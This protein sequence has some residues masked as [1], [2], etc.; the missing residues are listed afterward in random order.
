MNRYSQTRV[1]LVALSVVAGSI[2][3]LGTAD[4]SARRARPAAPPKSVSSRLL[5]TVPAIGTLEFRNFIIPFGHPGHGGPTITETVRLRSLITPSVNDA[6]VELKGQVGTT[7]PIELLRLELTGKS[8]NLGRV[9]VRAADFL[10][11]APE[12]ILQNVSSSPNGGIIGDPSF[13]DLQY[14]IFD[15]LGLISSLYGPCLGFGCG[16]NCFDLSQEVCDTSG[17]TCVSGRVGPLRCEIRE[18]NG[19]T[20]CA[21]VGAEDQDACNTLDITMEEGCGAIPTAA[22][23]FFCEEGCVDGTCQ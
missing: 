1:V 12:G 8:N 4:A 11:G 15:D 23:R 2:L 9:T 13:T 19:D 6:V 14:S 5:L 22:E 17:S 7:I 16:S 10:L 18:S 20:C 3:W 21:G